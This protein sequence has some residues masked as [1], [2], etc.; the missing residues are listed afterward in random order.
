MQY[1]ERYE[2]HSL[3]LFQLKNAVQ[4]FLKARGYEAD[5]LA[6]MLLS[7]IKDLPYVDP[8]VLYDMDMS[9]LTDEE[10]K[11][12]WEEDEQITFNALISSII[13][14]LKWMSS[15]EFW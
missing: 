14:Q 1:Y 4:E 12:L 3:L 6:Y 7:S 2:F 8:Y 11:A 5:R 13:E 9:S 10:L 15:R